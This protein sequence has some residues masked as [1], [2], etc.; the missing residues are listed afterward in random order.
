MDPRA[1][2]QPSL[3][4]LGE[5]NARIRELLEELNARQ[6]R[7]YKCSRREMFDTIERS[8]LAAL[9]TARFEYAEWKKARVN[10]DYHIAFDDHFYSVP[11]AHVHEEVWTR[12]TAQSI[13]IFHRGRRVA[14]HRRSNE[15]G[16]HTTV[17]EHMPSSHRAHAEWTPSRILDWAQKTG[18]SV[19]E[20]CAA[21][22]S[23]RRHPEQG[24]RSCL[25]IIGLVKSYGPGRV[26]A[27]CRRGNDIGATTY[28]SVASILR[29]GLDKPYLRAE[30]DVFAPETASEA[31]LHHGNIRGRDYYH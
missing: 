25:G 2:T 1:P 8:A 19:H 10:I 20:L 31:P 5:L 9:P 15:R 28:G 21:I 24:F 16:R 26:E 17:H 11:F 29:N 27:A 3:H 7:T 30:H 4:S 6:M 13:E 12:A 18:P 14:S 23:E 22:L